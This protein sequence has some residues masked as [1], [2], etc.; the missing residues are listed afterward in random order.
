MRILT[1][2]PGIAWSALLVPPANAEEPPDDSIVQET[3]Q[4]LRDRGLE[5]LPDPKSSPG[6]GGI[7][8][9]LV[10][11]QLLEA[12]AWVKSERLSSGDVAVYEVNRKLPGNTNL[13]D[14]LPPETGNAAGVAAAV[15]LSS[16][17]EYL[18]VVDIDMG[19]KTVSYTR[20]IPP[21]EVAVLKA[22]ADVIDD[23]T[24]LARLQA[25]GSLAVGTVLQA[26]VKDSP[27]G[28]MLLDG[29]AGIKAFEALSNSASHP[30]C[31]ALLDQ[32]TTGEEYGSLGPNHELFDIDP[33]TSL[34][35][36]TFMTGQ[37]CFL[38]AAADAIQGLGKVSP[39]TAQQIASAVRRAN[40]SFKYEGTDTVDGR[41]THKIAVD[42]V[43]GSLAGGSPSTPVG[44]MVAG[45]PKVDVKAM[46]KWIDA[47]YLVPRKLRIEGVMHAEGQSREFFLEKLEQ[48][49][50]NVPDSQLYEPYRTVLRMGGM[51]TPAQEAEMRESQG[52]LEEFERRMARMSPAERA[53]TTR[54]MGD[55]IEQWRSLANGGAVEFVII[56][57]AIVINPDFSSSTAMTLSPS[58]PDPVAPTPEEL[59]AAQLACL[60]ARAEA[61]KQAEK[62]RGGFGRLAG[63]VTGAVTRLGNSSIVRAASGALS[64]SDE[65]DELVAAARDLGL[66]E[67]DAAACR[68]P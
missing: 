20:V 53:L 65:S 44:P 3:I 46:Y 42:D 1:L 21:D 40:E 2:L 4:D 47:E 55:K 14:L 25:G 58:T 22:G 51:L 18:E 50:R 12:E 37:A 63:A 13:L 45:D 9:A 38:L 57:T 41:P 60:Q 33:W 54:M 8:D 6:K 24:N 16:I 10:A 27:F 43:G 30:I 26:A 29:T 31:P 19:G 35:P 64:S 17:S 62:K 34:N 52:K 11:S 67:E 68:A 28:S 39:E 49:Y 61:R 7:S 66:N 48:D 56:T 36:I 23:M 15:P 5:P 59:R 32:M